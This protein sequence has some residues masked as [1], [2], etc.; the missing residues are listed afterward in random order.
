MSVRM[1][2]ILTYED[3]ARVLITLV[4]LIDNSWRYLKEM[5]RR[6]WVA[7]LPR[8]DFEESFGD[9]EEVRLHR[10][11]VVEGKKFR[12]CTPNLRYHISGRPYESS[13]LVVL[14]NERKT[15]L[16]A[17][18]GIDIP[19]WEKSIDPCLR[20][21][22]K[23]RAEGRD[24][25][26]RRRLLVEEQEQIYRAEEIVTHS[27]RPAG[28]IER[29]NEFYISSIGVSAKALGFHYDEARSRSNRPVY[30]RPLTEAWSLCIS[31]EPLAW[32]SPKS[33]GEIRILLSLQHYPWNKPIRSVEPNRFLLIEYSEFVH[34]FEF[35]HRRFRTLDELNVL[36]LAR[37]DLL[38]LLLEGL[39]DALRSG[40]VALGVD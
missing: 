36:I 3:Q 14:S 30:S 33:E 12:I 37:M 28:Q 35:C 6:G 9:D 24:E 21:L 32:Y 8:I 2:R 11:I 5:R 20:R 31:A 22:E 38:S 19:D 23:L 1:E 16:A 18:Y 26:E 4:P 34:Y 17:K 15:T 29:L 13:F 10:S 40:L 27:V 7:T 25:F 39:E